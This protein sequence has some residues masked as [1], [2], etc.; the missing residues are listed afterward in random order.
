MKQI[1]TAFRD[2]AAC[3]AVILSGAL[4]CALAPAAFAQSWPAKPVRAIFPSPGG[5]GLE[6]LIRVLA[7][8]LSPMWGQPVI[9]E[10]RPG[11]NTLLGTEFVARSAPDGYTLLIT[12]DQ[13]FTINPHLYAKL[14]YDPLKDFQPVTRLVAL[15][16]LMVVNPSLPALN[17]KEL[18]ALAKAKPGFYSYASYG[19]G[20]HAH[21]GTEMLKSKAGIDLVHVPYKGL[22]QAQMA[23]IGG[24]IPITWSGVASSLGSVRAGRLR[25]I[26]I[27]GAKRVAQLPELP[28]FAELGFPEVDAN[29]WFGVF[30]PAATP[31]PIVDRIHADLVKVMADTGFREKEVL[32]KGYE[33]SGFGPDEFSAFIRAEI[34]R[35]REVVR[36][37]GARVE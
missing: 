23:V 29:A 35:R 12:S 25:A 19:S 4:C 16:Q 31:R 8:Q 21:L 5:G 1:I 11:A 18:I 10:S 13:T 3:L 2:V 20:S 7:N 32:A 37:S 36:I 9:V 30:V 17:L 28:T 14:P 33:Y 34:E 6:V 26:A 24:E 15:S 22:A 27:S